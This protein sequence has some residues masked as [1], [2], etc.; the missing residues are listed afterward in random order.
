MEKYTAE[1]KSNKDNLAIIEVTVEAQEAESARQKALA[2]MAKEVT[3]KGFRKGMAPVA[4]VEKELDPANVLQ[5]A[6]NKIV[7]EI[8]DSAL[9]SGEYKV[10]TNPHIHLIEAKKGGVWKFEIEIPLQP[11]LDLSDIEEYVKGEVKASTLWT[12]E[13]G[14][15]EEKKTEQDIQGE[16]LSKILEALLKKYKVTVPAIMIEDEVSQS[17]GRL[18]S[19]LETL[20]ISLEDYLKSVGKTA[21]EIRQE[22]A[23]AAS[24]NLALEI[25]L[26]RA[27][28]QLKIEVSDAEVDSMIVASGDQK[29]QERLNTPEQKAYI[30]EILRKRK[31]IDALMSL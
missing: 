23:K 13:K 8:L 28:S 21:D 22:Y 14:S 2:E 12:P 16:K 19:Q 9:K 1:V 4:M 7:P 20:N 25:I 27:G 5:R 24:E 31:T 3:I 6:V 26:S 18:L 10:L 29:T 11:E 17:L 30:R 15:T